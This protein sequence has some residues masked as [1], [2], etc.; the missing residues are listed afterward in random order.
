MEECPQENTVQCTMDRRF[1]GME[2]VEKLII[3]GEDSILCLYRDWK[4]D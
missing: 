4:Y 1:G 2:A 3:C